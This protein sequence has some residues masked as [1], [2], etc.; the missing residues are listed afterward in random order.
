MTYADLHASAAFYAPLNGD[1]SFTTLAADPDAFLNTYTTLV[2]DND[3]PI[4]ETTQSMNMGDSNGTFYVNPAINPGLHNTS[5]PNEFGS[6]E[7][8]AISLWYKQDGPE[9]PA[10]NADLGAASQTFLHHNYSTASSYDEYLRVFHGSTWDSSGIQSDG[11]MSWSGARYVTT[12]SSSSTLSSTTSDYKMYPGKW[13]H[14]VFT[15]KFQ[16]VPGVATSKN[17]ERAVYV[18]GALIAHDIQSNINGVDNSYEWLYDWGSNWYTDFLGTVSSTSV[19]IAPRR[20]AHFA[21]WNKP[22]TKAEIEALAWYGKSEDYN[23]IVLSDNP[24]AYYTFNNIDKNTDVDVY[25]T[26]NWAPLSDDVEGIAV[27]QESVMGKSWKLQHPVSNTSAELT[28]VNTDATMMNDLTNIIK[29]GEYS[30]E[31]WFKSPE[32]NLPVYPRQLVTIDGALEDGNMYFIQA[33][34]GDFNVTSSRKTGTTTYSTTSTRIN[35][36]EFAPIASEWYLPFSKD[37]KWS[38]GQ[39]H[40]IAFV[41]SLSKHASYTTSYLPEIYIDG[42]KDLGNASATY[43]YI[44]GTGLLTSLM[45]N[46]GYNNNATATYADTNLDFY[47]DKLAVY[48][49]AFTDDQPLEHYVAGRNYAA[50]PTGITKYWDGTDWQTPTEVRVFD[51]TNWVDWTTL[52]RQ[53]WDGTQW[54]TL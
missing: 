15:F 53:R 54:V 32:A 23:A 52:T 7:G 48:N 16:D 1:I 37:Y 8:Q 45:L 25:G 27:N 33:S 21:I 17:I 29:S 10:I 39:W 31:F 24:V 9:N 49:Y 36:I 22:L 3:S 2:F 12:A 13:H 43:G 30:I 4:S 6:Y 50:T 18:D 14:I 5:F 47:I 41:F 40:H 26:G 35:N 11:K 44:D 38:D 46:Y 42:N 28:S 51:G 19:G 34:N 20:I